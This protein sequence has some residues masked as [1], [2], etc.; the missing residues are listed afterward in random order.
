M[1]G[2]G[3][4]LTFFTLVGQIKDNLEQVGVTLSYAY[5]LNSEKLLDILGSFYDSLALKKWNSNH[6]ILERG[7]QGARS[8]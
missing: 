5:I 4:S 6:I 1:V 2:K 3:K 8:L 7:W